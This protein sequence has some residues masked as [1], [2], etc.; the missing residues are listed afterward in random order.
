MNRHPGL[1]ILIISDHYPPF[2]GG[3]HRQTQLL[4]RE[5]FRRG[6][7][8]SVVTVWH[9]GLPEYED[10][11]GVAVYRLKQIRTWLPWFARKHGQR[12]Q[13]PFPD[14]ITV[15]GLRR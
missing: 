14:P 9:P 2:I 1:R 11:G 6:H 4:S 5:L 15:W 7:A 12:H 3:A 10:D 8:V 13:P